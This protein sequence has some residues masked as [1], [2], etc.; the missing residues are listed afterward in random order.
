MKQ[1][2]ELQ[3][4]AIELYKLLK[5]TGVAG[6]G[7]TAKVLVAEGEVTVDDEVELRKRCK[8]RKGQVVRCGGE[9]IEVL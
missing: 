1:S 4:E 8:V 2:F 3:G 6:S 9:E 5:L 7:G